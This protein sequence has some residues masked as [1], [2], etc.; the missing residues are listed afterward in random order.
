MSAIQKLIRQ[1]DW[2]L[3]DILL[4]D[5]PPGTGDTQLTITQQ[6]PVSGILKKNMMIVIIIYNHRGSDSNNPSRY[7]SVGCKTRC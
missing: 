6:I 1:V 5:M 4:V 2:G 7:C 3:L